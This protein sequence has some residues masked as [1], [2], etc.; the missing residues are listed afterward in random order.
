[1]RRRAP[2]ALALSAVA[3]MTAACGT[4]LPSSAFNVLGSGKAVVRERVGGESG[5]LGATPTAAPSASAAAGSQGTQGTQGTS[6]TSGGSNGAAGSKGGSGGCSGTN[7]ASDTGVSPNEIKIGVLYSGAGNPFAPNQFVV[8]YYGVSSYFQYLNAQGGICGRKITVVPCDDSG[9]RNKDVNC[10]RTLIDQ[11]KVFALVG[12]N[13]Y[14]YAGAQYVSQSKVPDI[15]GEP[16][17]GNAYYTYPYLYS[18]L[19]SYYPNN[20]TPPASYYGLS[21]LGQYFKKTLNI[22]KAG[23]IYYGQADSQ[24]GASYIEGW[25]NGAGVQTIPEEVALAGDP[26]Q[27]VNDLKSKGAQAIF[28]ALDLTGNQKVCRAMQNYSF[29]VPKI[30]TISTWTQEAGQVLSSYPCINNYYAWGN[31][32]NYADTSDPQAQLFQKAYSSFA[33]GAPLSQWSLEGWAAGMWFNDAAKS[34]GA[35]LTRACVEK[36]VDSPKGYTAG[37][38]LDAHTTAFP[39]YNSRPPQLTACYTIV[40]WGGGAGGTWQTVAD[41]KSNCFTTASFSYQGG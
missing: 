2:A 8:S 9:D 34:C 40:K 14:E 31:S 36:F 38:L 30:S 27:Q 41:H 32:T 26:S 11:D 18:I 25:L 21:G 37:G 24:R 20:G 23:V 39:H 16:V 7:T 13:V 3:L 35:Q 22:T 17:T 12:T 29:N 19:G 28:D 33:H 6:A 15:G 4:T 10:V 5:A 1:M